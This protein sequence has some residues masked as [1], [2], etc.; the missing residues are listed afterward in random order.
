MHIYCNRGKDIALIDIQI[1]LLLA[2]YFMGLYQNSNIF[3]NHITHVWNMFFSSL[4][5]TPVQK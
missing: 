3:V 2:E 5:Y 1:I 4:M